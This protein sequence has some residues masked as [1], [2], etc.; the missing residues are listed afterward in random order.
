MFLQGSSGEKGEP[1]P[2]G[3]VGPRVG[4]SI[5]LNKEINEYYMNERYYLKIE[6]VLFLCRG[7]PD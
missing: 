6:C 4:Y 7:F 3:P 1:G 2:S 5:D